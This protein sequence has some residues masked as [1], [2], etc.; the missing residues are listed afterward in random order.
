MVSVE[1]MSVQVSRPM[2]ESGPLASRISLMT[3]RAPLPESGRISAIGST[4][5]GTP[6]PLVSG[7]IQ[8]TTTSS[9]PEARNMPSATR[10]TTR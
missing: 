9:A 8:P 1:P 6:S 4:S 7:S 5:A 10:I 2:K 3:P